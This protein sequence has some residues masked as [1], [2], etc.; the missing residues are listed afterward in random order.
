MF[1]C[2][3]NLFHVLLVSTY[4]LLDAV[5]SY[6]SGWIETNLVP[7]WTHEMQIKI[8]EGGREEGREGGREEGRE[9]GWGGG[10]GG[11][12]EDVCVCVCREGKGGRG[13]EKGRRGREKGRRGRD[14]IVKQEKVPHQ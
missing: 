2:V 3:L 13:R 9:G 12:K 8:C 10:G 14:W 4:S 11:R 5:V 1:L 6:L 7:A